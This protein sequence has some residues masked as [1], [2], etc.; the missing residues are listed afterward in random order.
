M[1][2]HQN[3]LKN[4]CRV[5]AGRPKKYTHNKNSDTC[6][7]LLLSAFGVDVTGEPED[8]YPTSVCNSCFR[9]M[10]RISKSKSTGMLLKTSLTIS[11]WQPHSD[12]CQVCCCEGGGGGRPKKRKVCAGRPCADD[13]THLGREIMK[14]V[15][16]INPPLFSD[17][18]L[19]PSRF[20]PTPTLSSLQCQHCHYIPNK[21]IELLP[22][23]HLLC[24]S[25]I[26]AATT[27]KILTCSCS[28]TEV[29]VTEPHP[30]VLQLLGNLLLNCP[31]E[32][33]EVIQL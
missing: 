27:T 22:C 29:T 30:V 32:C 28:S 11:S 10:Q 6:T 25:C 4:L 7:S 15:N 21:P 18:P 5:C 9:S 31:G 14:A 3:H 12:S 33:G 2:E 8:V 1:E 24:V 23:H 26:Q 20:L 16:V 19:C 17:L 13:V